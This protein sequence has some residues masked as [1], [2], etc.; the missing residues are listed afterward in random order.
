MARTIVHTGG[1]DKLFKPAV[2]KPVGTYYLNMK[3]VELIQMV[4]SRR[5]L[6]ENAS[7]EV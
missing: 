7:S 6:I 1:V 2:T 3:P 5:C 4:Q